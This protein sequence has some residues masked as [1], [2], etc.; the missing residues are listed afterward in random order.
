MDMQKY[1]LFINAILVFLICSTYVLAK[2]TTRATKVFYISGEEIQSKEE[3]QED[4]NSIDLNSKEDSGFPFDEDESEK[5]KVVP[6]LTAHQKA[7]LDYIFMEE[8]GKISALDKNL[9]TA[10]KL[11]YLELLKED[12]N[13]TTIKNLKQEIT[14]TSSDIETVR[15]ET[16]CKIRGIVSLDQYKK[17]EKRIQKRR[18][19]I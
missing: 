14:K 12:Y 6:E 7:K 2:E 15:F 4:Q 1:K 13:L 17:L 8:Q 16:E 5:K 3:K 10:K 11:F 18:K 19:E 9:Q